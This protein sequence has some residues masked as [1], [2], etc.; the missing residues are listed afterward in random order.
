MPKLP[1]VSARK[2][3]K[4]LRK[5]GFELDH[6]TGSHHIFRH[7]LTKLRASVPIHHG[8]DLGRGL[9]L[10]ILKD[11]KITPTEFVTLL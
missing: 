1:V 9:T 6:S 5:K 11:A 3:I 10:A 2:L 7:P 4:V 8:K